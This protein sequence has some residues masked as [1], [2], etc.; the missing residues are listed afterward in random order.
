MNR[1]NYPMA[2]YTYNNMHLTLLK[3]YLITLHIN[4]SAECGYSADTH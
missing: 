3:F 2:G 4:I 1:G